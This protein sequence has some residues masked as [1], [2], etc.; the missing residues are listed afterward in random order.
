MHKWGQVHQ[1]YTAILGA[2]RKPK[3]PLCRR[4]ACR[5]AGAQT[6]VTG[7]WR[8]RLGKMPAIRKSGRRARC[9]TRAANGE[10]TEVVAQVHWA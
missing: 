9:Y 10:A 5:V 7:A 1:R 3:P 2:S 6:L 8:C 4:S